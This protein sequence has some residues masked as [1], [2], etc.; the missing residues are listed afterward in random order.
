MARIEG[1][2]YFKRTDAGN[3]H[4]EYSNKGSITPDVEAAQMKLTS[5][6]NSKYPFIGKYFATWTETSSSGITTVSSDL[7]IKLKDG[8]NNLFSV[9]WTTRGTTLFLGE[10]MIVDGILIGDYQS[11]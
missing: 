10:G 6:S 4:G 11:K 5:L 7:E 9:M 3:L 1:R 2:F 8:V